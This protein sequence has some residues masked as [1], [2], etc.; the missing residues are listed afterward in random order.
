ML[1]ACP[2]FEDNQ[3]MRARLVALFTEARPASVTVLR[4]EVPPCRGIAAVCHEAAEECGT[5]FVS[6]LWD[7]MGSCVS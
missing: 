3:E 2:K 5:L 6:L 4:M 1:I 7:A